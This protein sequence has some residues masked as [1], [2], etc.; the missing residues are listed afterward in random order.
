MQVRSYSRNAGSTSDEIETIEMRMTFAHDLR[1]T[2]F[3]RRIQEGEQKADRDRLDAFRSERIGL[4]PHRF[5]VQRQQDLAACRHALRHFTPQ[6]AGHEKPGRLRFEHDAVDVATALAADLE[7]VLEAVRR[8]QADLRALALE[9]GVRRD[10]RAVDESRDVFCRRC[11]TPRPCAGSRASH[12]RSGWRA[13]WESSRAS[14][15]RPRCGKR[16]R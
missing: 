12:P 10:R 8:D 4:T 15:H 3:V 14:S 16:R 1:R 6:S 2:P 13:S 7:H 9:H 5:F 11:S